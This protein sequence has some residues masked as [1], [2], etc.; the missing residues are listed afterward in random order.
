MF[1]YPN[2]TSAAKGIFKMFVINANNFG[3]M[4][5]WA[6]VFFVAVA[7]IGSLTA[8]PAIFARKKSGDNISLS[9]GKWTAIIIGYVS[10]LIVAG[11][12]DV[13]VKKSDIM[14][15]KFPQMFL[16]DLNILNVSIFSLAFTLLTV[17]LVTNAIILSVDKVGKV[18]PI[19]TAL[20]FIIYILLV[21]LDYVLTLFTINFEVLAIIAFL[22]GVFLVSLLYSRKKN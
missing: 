18:V 17:A 11:A 3:F 9:G 4:L 22:L 2:I 6:C 21:L 10:A 13:F 15:F 16:K 20:A 7:A 8:L 19:G 5:I 12:V 1:Y 14:V